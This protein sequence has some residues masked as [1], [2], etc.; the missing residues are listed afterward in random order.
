[1]T[2]QSVEAVDAPDRPAWVIAYAGLV[3]VTVF[4]SVVL[5]IAVVT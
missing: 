5:V 1:M 3:A 4:A 2:D